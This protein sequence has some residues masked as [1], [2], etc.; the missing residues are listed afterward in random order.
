MA[1][2][3]RKLLTKRIVIILICLALFVGAFSGAIYFY[4]SDRTQ[5]SANLLFGD[6]K[7][8]NRMEVA[9]TLLGV[10]PIKGEL[11]SVLRLY[12]KVY[13]LLRKVA[14]LRS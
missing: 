7:E 10:D 14:L 8:P 6:D 1:D 3:T 4:Q 2:T 5:K 13:M 12:Q 11:N 9:V